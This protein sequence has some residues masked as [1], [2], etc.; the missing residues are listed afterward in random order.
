M[1]EDPRDL[2]RAAQAAELAKDLSGAVALL[3][4]AAAIYRAQGRDARAEQLT[5]HAERLHEPPQG[6]AVSPERGTSTELGA[7]PAPSMGQ[8]LAASAPSDER[9]PRQRVRAPLPDRGPE[10]AD[11]AVE[12]WC[13]FCCRPARE[14]GRLVTGPTG[15]FICRACADEAGQKLE[16]SGSDTRASAVRP[17]RDPALARLS[18]GM[19]PSQQEAV[20]AIERAIA[21]GAQRILL[22][23]AVGVGKS[24][25][26]EALEHRGVGRPLSEA[27]AGE[28]ALVEEDALLGPID[29]RRIEA[30][31]RRPFVLASVGGIFYSRFTV[32]GPEQ[33]ALPT[34]A[35]LAEATGNRL[36]NALLESVDRAV[37]LRA[38]TEGELIELARRLLAEAD[39]PRKVSERLL[40]TLAMGAMDSGRAAHEL[41]SLI[42]RLPP[43]EWDL[44]PEE[45]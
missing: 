32:V 12:A 37:Q 28:R 2:I 18:R 34:T 21:S 29:E 30:L 43:G 9:T 41:G 35:D 26:L 4:R 10:L 15:S 5:R 38:P 23:G 44:V 13:S 7:V 40:R 16:R 22:V 24:R 11:D 19:L 36:P 39:P 31:Q 14:V 20:D 3:T 17:D 27:G 1:P 33:L 42:S 6:R 8:N 25:V 45:R